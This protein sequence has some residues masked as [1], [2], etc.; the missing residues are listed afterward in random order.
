MRIELLAKRLAEKTGT[1][2]LEQVVLKQASVLD[3]PTSCMIG[4]GTMSGTAGVPRIKKV[5]D[6]QN[7][8][9]MH[10]VADRAYSIINHERRRVSVPRLIHLLAFSPKYEFRMR[11]LCET[12]RCV[13]PLHWAVDDVQPAGPSPEVADFSF[14]DNDWSAEDVEELVEILLTE[15]SPETW[16]DVV[17]APIMD[18]APEDLIRKGLT[19]L[20]KRHLC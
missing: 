8:P 20:G 12:S 10:M 9:Y 18:G 6:S 7:L 16:K 14:P 19:K 2:L 3:L 5:R 13:N 1:P 11:A 4:T 15:S 17:A